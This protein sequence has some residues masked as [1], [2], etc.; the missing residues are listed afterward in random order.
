[1]IPFFI[2]FKTTIQRTLSCG[3]GFTLVETIVAVG[4]IVLMI[5]VPLSGYIQSSKMIRGE[6]NDLTA[7]Y[8]QQE[9][10]ELMKMTI[11]AGGGTVDALFKFSSYDSA[12]GRDVQRGYYLAKCDGTCD[13]DEDPRN[14]LVGTYPLNGLTRHLY[15]C[16]RWRDATGAPTQYYCK[17]GYDGDL[18]FSFPDNDFSSGYPISAQNFVVAGEI[19]TTGA[20][21]ALK[22]CS[23]TSAYAEN[24][25][26]DETIFKRNV[27]L[28][29][30]DTGV[31]A[32]CI[33]TF[34]P[35]A[36]G[37]D[38]DDGSGHRFYDAVRLTSS[39]TWVGRKANLPE[40]STV[41]YRP[42]LNECK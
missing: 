3:G 38:Y 39:A 18:P 30:Q 23:I 34:G 8:L 2:N 31:R 21:Y 26:G 13:P 19:N 14:I 42:F 33:K 20:T 10:V 40:L 1:M 11:R 15:K 27:S 36:Y 6:M 4:I 17:I 24:C 22:K 7:A 37:A 12:L 25:T 35:D 9:A 16:G 32:F 41:M 29:L 5:T 28:E